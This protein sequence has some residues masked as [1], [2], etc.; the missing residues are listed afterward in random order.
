M[1]RAAVDRDFAIVILAGGAATRFPGKLESDA[2]GV[3][4][5]VRVYQNVRFVGPV[6]IS[7]TEPFPDRVARELDCPI[8]PDVVG[9]LGPLC[10]L[11][12][13][14]KRLPYPRAFAVAGDAPFVNASV[15]RT[16]LDHWEDGLEAVAAKRSGRLEPLC[17]LY[18]RAAFLREG[19]SELGTSGSVAGVVRRLRHKS[20]TFDRRILA[21]INTPA[22]RRALLGTPS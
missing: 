21:N 8:V 6:V 22:D 3:P 2:G 18:D 16:L 1:P 19:I 20:V 11:L 7:R 12:S 5:I 10:G 15:L 14:F 4:L 9:G 13:T 17:A